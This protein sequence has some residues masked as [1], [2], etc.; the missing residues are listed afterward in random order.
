MKRPKKKKLSHAQIK[1]LMRIKMYK[2]IRKEKIERI[3]SFI[4]SISIIISISFGIFGLIL[5]L[6]L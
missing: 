1:V 2:Q 3:I 4:K 6:S 5:L